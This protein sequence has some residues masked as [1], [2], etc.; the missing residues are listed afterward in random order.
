MFESIRKRFQK[1][2]ALTPSHLISGAVITQF[3]DQKNLVDGLPTWEHAA[4]GKDDLELMVKCC[5]TELE[6]MERVGIVAAP[7]YFERVA[8]LL[9]K[10]GEAEREIEICDRYIDAVHRFY[11]CRSSESCADVRKGPRF[12]AIERRLAAA[13]L[14]LSRGK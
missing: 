7:Y 13:R 9:R 3:A 10:A 11:S 5:Y 12:A 14:R 6:T 4:A 1:Q 8:V 2:V